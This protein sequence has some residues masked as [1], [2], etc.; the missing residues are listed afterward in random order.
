M[1]SI[2]PAFT[3]LHARY[4]ALPAQ[5]RAAG[6]MM[7]A[8]V[9]FAFCI[10]MIKKLGESLHVTEII[11]IRQIFVVGALLPALLRAP[12]ANLKINR[13][14]LQLL[15]SFVTFFAILAGFTAIIHLPLATA[16]TLSF[17]RT[18]FVT[19]F[20]IFI[21][22]ES[23]GSRRLGALIVGFIGILI[24]ARPAELF[25]NGLS[26]LDINILLAV[27]SSACIGANQIIIRIH[28]R[29]DQPSLMVASQALLIGIAMAPLAYWNWKTPTWEEV[30]ILGFIGLFTSLA[31][32]LMVNAFKDAE[33]TFLAPF[34]YLRLILSTAIGWYLFSEWPD[35]FT[36]IG[37]AI[38]FASTFYILRREAILKR[39]K[40]PNSIDEMPVK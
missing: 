29:Y 26:G 8:M 35:L 39:T 5:M 1:A 6:Q 15:R 10:A 27:F 21:L 30:A 4:Q 34:D 2:P 24:V 14:D 32:W 20:A 11:A 18:F 22:H 12:S 33:A 40:K 17:T 3:A 23:V 7:V 31:Q 9:I 19:L 38:I 37:A 16:T 36:W 13:P 25:A 28:A